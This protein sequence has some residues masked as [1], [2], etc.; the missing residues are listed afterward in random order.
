MR[1]ISVQ[2][3]RLVAD[4]LMSTPLYPNAETPSAVLLLEMNVRFQLRR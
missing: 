1:A 3:K 4:Q 2:E